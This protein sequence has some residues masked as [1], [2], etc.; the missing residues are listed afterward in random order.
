MVGLHKI[1]LQFSIHKFLHT[2]TPSQEGIYSIPF[3]YQSE[4][5]VIP[6]ERSDEE[7]CSFHWIYVS[8]R[9]SASAVRGN[10]LNSLGIASSLL[11][12]QWQNEDIVF[13]IIINLQQP[14]NL[15][16]LSGGV[17]GGCFCHT[18]VRNFLYK[19]I[20]HKFSQPA[21]QSTITQNPPL[22]GF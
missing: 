9:A 11:S 22:A 19:L 3:L 18:H 20:Y 16:P 12:S 8:L 5:N 10:L 13:Q 14:K 21:I 1:W 4:M 2:P 15:I 17:R 7:S 6:S